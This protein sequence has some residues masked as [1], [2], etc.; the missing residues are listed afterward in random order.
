MVPLATLWTSRAQHLGIT[1]HH[2]STQKGRE[3]TLN[4]IFAHGAGFWQRT[5]DFESHG[6]QLLENT[7]EEIRDIVVEMVER[8]QPVRIERYELI[9]DSGGPGK[10]RGGLGLRR[11]LR[12]LEGHARLTVLADRMRYGPYGL[13]GGEQGSF[14]EIIIN[15]DSPDERKLPG[16]VTGVEL[17][18]GDIISIRTSGGGGWGNTREREREAVQQDIELGKISHQAAE[19]IYGF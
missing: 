9:P 4:E 14:T 3:L 12:I 13:N 7:P 10:H 1:R 15:P 17:K 5:S 16:K 8:I 6:I 19:E 18:G 11:D 2:Y